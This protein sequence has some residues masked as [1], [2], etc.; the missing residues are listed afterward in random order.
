MHGADYHDTLGDFFSPDI[1]PP[2]YGGE[3]PAIEEVCQDWT[4]QLL[5][6]EQLLQK[7]ATHPTGDIAMAADDCLISEE[8]DNEQFSEG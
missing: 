1:L 2:E 4:N 3:G 7:I 8:A 5:K 6:S